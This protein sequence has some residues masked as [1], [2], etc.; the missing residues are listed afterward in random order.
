MLNNQDL[1][2]EFCD[3][4]NADWIKFL[5]YEHMKVVPFNANEVKKDTM[6]IVS[7]LKRR[8]YSSTIISKH[9][10]QVQA[11][12]MALREQFGITDVPY[13]LQ[14]IYRPH[15]DQ[16]GYSRSFRSHIVMLEPGDSKEDMIKRDNIRS[17]KKQKIVLVDNGEF[18]AYKELKKINGFCA[19]C[20]DQKLCDGLE[21]CTEKDNVT[22]EHLLME[23]FGAL[24][25]DYKIRCS[26]LGDECDIEKLLGSVNDEKLP[27]ELQFP[28]DSSAIVGTVLHTAFNGQIVDDF[29]PNKDLEKIGLKPVSRKDYCEYV[30]GLDIGKGCRIS[31]RCDTI[32]MLVKE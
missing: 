20:F 26:S 30:L 14:V 5:T 24:A 8:F 11:Y 10:M 13:F 23:R 22:L 12:A 15:P 18:K 31:G 16:E 17:Y 9:G 32:H 1:L 2:K 25:K 3:E 19:K 4:P 28:V 29:A 7:D 27:P 6:I 21:H